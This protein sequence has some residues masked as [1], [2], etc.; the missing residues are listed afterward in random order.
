VATTVSFQQ[1]AGGYSGMSATFFDCAAGYNVAPYLRVG[2]ATCVRSLVR[3][4]VASLPAAASV[5]SASLALYWT[6]RTNSNSLTLA[7]H[8]VLVDWVD[9][10]ATRAYR[11][12]G[13]PWSAAGL[14]PGADYEAAAASTRAFT[15]AESAGKWIN[16]DV[17]AMVGAWVQ[18]PASNKGLVLL[19]SQASGAVI[20][21]FGSEW[22]VNPPK[23]TVTYLP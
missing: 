18:N 20:Y 11:L 4:D 17:T 2:F 3:F 6:E 1:G 8:R 14:G 13:V 21:S 16:L 10:Q 12:S 9:S 7:V 5:Q 19:Q 15:G 23:L 22:G